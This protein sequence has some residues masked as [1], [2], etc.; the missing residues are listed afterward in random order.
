MAANSSSRETVRD[1]LTGL[2]T[3]ALASVT[4]QVYGYRVSDF[5]TQSPVVMVSSAGSQRYIDE[6]GQE[7]WHTW[8]YFNVLVFTVYAASGWTPATAADAQDA[9]EKA[10]ADCVMDNY[11]TANWLK[12]EFVGQ[13][14]ADEV[15]EEG[16]EAYVYEVI[17]VRAFVSGR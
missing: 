12:L 13:T 9:I 8:F 16:G 17:P 14:I 7:N 4:Q 6:E 1:A 10:V 11:S 2:L 15:V 3:T 5:G